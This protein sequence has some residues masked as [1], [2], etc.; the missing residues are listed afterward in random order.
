MK[1]LKKSLFFLLI[2]I[3]LAS[4]PSVYN[5]YK[6]SETTEKI[7]ELN[8]TKINIL[9]NY[10]DYRGIVHVHSYL[11]GHSNGTF[12][13]L[14]SAANSNN[15]DFVVMT[16]HYSTAFDTSATTL[17]GFHGK[18]IFVNGNEIDTANGDRFLLINGSQEASGFA[19][20]ST[21]E[22]LEKIHSENKFTIVAYPHKFQSWES[23]FDGIEVFSLNTN[24]RNM[25]PIYF[26]FDSL[27]AY[28]K[29]PQ[30]SLTKYFRRPNEN[31]KK[32]D[33]ISQKR[34]IALFG[35]SD[36]HSN[37]GIKLFSDQTGKSLFE[38]KLDPYE[39]ILPILQTHILLKKDEKL[40]Q[41][42]LLQALKNGKFFIGFD[43]LGDSSGFNFS[44]NDY[45]MGDE[46]ELKDKIT[47]KATAP[48]MSRFIL[49]RNGEKILEHTETTEINFE[50]KEPGTYRVEVYL[51][52]LGNSFN[53]IPWIIS[54]PIY[55]K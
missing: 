22:V 4:I 44:A 26:F 36:A 24:A 49:Y 48:Q 34:K 47:M 9:S 20:K 23:N 51:N 1:L 6:L 38:I 21:N 33:E 27:W 3:V 29:Y 2:V 45:I 46:I 25:N 54:N 40:T 50:T 35:G 5:R 55:L 7:A 10:Q 53:S 15:L 8:S 41:E 14:I 19:K 39:V 11:G 42:N 52:S 12:Y 32:F 17:Q 18:T 28:S 30:L 37:I 16:E 13:E 31:L 43:V